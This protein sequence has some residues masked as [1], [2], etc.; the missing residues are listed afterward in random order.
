MNSIIC[1]NCNFEIEYSDVNDEFDNSDCAPE[2][3]MECP[4]CD[5]ELIISAEPHI[6]FELI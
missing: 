4:N 6:I 2:F 5:K 1:P 3:D